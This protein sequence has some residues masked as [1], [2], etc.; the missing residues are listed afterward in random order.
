MNLVS[1]LRA[2]NKPT[3]APVQA[4]ATLTRK[5]K[6]K[7]TGSR[8]RYRRFLRAEPRTARQIAVEFGYTESGVRS[9]LQRFKK[10][11]LVRVVGTLRNESGGRPAD[12]HSWVG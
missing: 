3:S 1:M 2:A 5:Q 11:G 6:P 8:D 12:L 4:A 10:L 9:T 7:H